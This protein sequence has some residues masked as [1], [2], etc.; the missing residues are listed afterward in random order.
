MRDDG[1]PPAGTLKRRLDLRIDTS[2]ITQKGGSV[3]R[4]QEDQLRRDEISK[5]REARAREQQEREKEQQHSSTMDSV[6]SSS[7][8]TRGLGIYGDDE[9]RDLSA[10]RGNGHDAPNQQQQQHDMVQEDNE[11]DD[12]DEDDDEEDDDDALSSSPSIPDEHIDFDLVYALHTFLATVEGQAS[13]VKGD[14][15]TLLDDSNSYWWLVRVLKTQAVGYIPAENIETPFER[16]ARLNKH[17]N[18]DVRKSQHISFAKPVLTSFTACLQLAFATSEDHMNGIGS[19]LAQT[20]FAQPHHPTNK[21]LKQTPVQLNPALAGGGRFVDFAPPIYHEHEGFYYSDSAEGEGEY[22]EYGYD[23]EEGQ[24]LDEDDDH[25]DEGSDGSFEGGSAE[26]LRSHHNMQQQSQEG[27][28]D[29]DEEEDHD[30][31]DIP[32]HADDGLQNSLTS[33]NKDHE[34]SIRYHDDYTHASVEQREALQPLSPGQTG[35]NFARTAQAQQQ[36]ALGVGRP[37]QVQAAY[38]GLQTT[39]PTS[40]GRGVVRKI[41]IDEQLRMEQEATRPSNQ[42]TTSK[43]PFTNS[44]PD[45]KGGANKAN[46]ASAS[47]SISQSRLKPFLHESGELTA[48]TSKHDAAGETRKIS[49]TPRIARDTS[50]DSNL[51]DRAW[52]PAPSNAS[53]N[54]Y[55][56]KQAPRNISGASSNAASGAEQYANSGSAQIPNAGGDYEGSDHFRRGSASSA[57][58]ASSMSSSLSGNAAKSDKRSSSPANAD[59]QQQQ[60]KKKKSSGILGGLFSRSKKDKEKEKDKDSK[61]SN[62]TSGRK[63]SAS[64]ISDDERASSSGSPAPASPERRN[65]AS[66]GIVTQQLQQRRAKEAASEVFGTGAALR[67]QQVEAQNAMFNQYGIHP[68]SPGDISNVSTFSAS[69][70]PSGTQ[71]VGPS[72]GSMTLS[73]STASNMSLLN[74]GAG[75]KPRRPGSLIGSPHM[76]VSASQGGEVPILNVLRVFAGENIHSEA[77]FKTVLL[78][79]STTTEDLV[80]QAMQRFRLSPPADAVSTDGTL[81]TRSLLS[82]YYLTAKEMNG[83]ETLLEGGQKPLRIFENLAEGS[84]NFNPTAGLPAV[85]RSSVGSINSIASN[86]S[87]HPS[88]EKLRMSDFSDDSVVKLFINKRTPDLEH[89]SLVEDAK[90]ELPERASEDS[91]QIDASRL[92]ASGSI[93]D[94]GPAPGMPTSPLL[95]FAVRVIIHPQ[96]LPESMT[97][98]PSSPAI[99]PK[100]T[101]TERSNRLTASQSVNAVYREK[102]LFFP[103]NANVS[104]VVETA[105]DRFGIVEGVVDGGDDIEDKLA[106]RRSISRVRYSLA[107]RQSNKGK[108]TF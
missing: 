104:E 45:V 31:N 47:S 50:Q 42:D 5:R 88:I 54:A 39:S 46:A 68:R 33:R 106:K 25:E 102:I 21:Y 98:D 16:L 12:E 8:G 103:R 58:T 55:N 72:S 26:D 80:K 74:V 18:V 85:K 17:R 94:R 27:F 57:V 44:Q 35:G 95:R 83:D 30:M 107:V 69:R 13:V 22:S 62:S 82:E 9:D 61:R 41:S 71:G 84:G 90:G 14:S 86:L 15:L 77:T 73:P 7:N 56:A 93:I 105:L 52:S 34:N 23:N 70:S 76:S 6:N 28:D 3:A 81:D 10:N 79:D 60:S 101:L 59:T 97:F 29:D 4:Q 36:A 24:G 75:S 91:F 43:A 67:Q 87:M 89:Q 48:S 66:A 40:E 65:Q 20:R 99:I 64:T 53:Q 1:D 38:G 96:D 92:S 78:N 2:I 49:L 11:E 32:E 19:S 51:S 37:T 108:L 100:A 63:S